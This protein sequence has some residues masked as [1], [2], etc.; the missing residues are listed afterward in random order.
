L[1]SVLP[2]QLADSGLN[3]VMVTPSDFT[4]SGTAEIAVEEAAKQ[5]LT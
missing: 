4:K 5:W 3:V 1:P 2:K